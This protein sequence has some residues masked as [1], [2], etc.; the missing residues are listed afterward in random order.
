MKFVKF[1]QENLL[2]RFTVAFFVV[3]EK[4]DSAI[5]IGFFFFVFEW[6]NFFFCWWA[7]FHIEFIDWFKYDADVEIP[8]RK[9]SKLS[10]NAARRNWPSKIVKA[11]TMKKRRRGLVSYLISFRYTVFDYKDVSGRGRAHCLRFFL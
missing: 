5:F 9:K 7:L 6:W 8:N 4:R 10:S 3:W 1:G 2:V 11:T